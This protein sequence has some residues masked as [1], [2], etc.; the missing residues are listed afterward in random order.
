MTHKELMIEV[1]MLKGNIN[2]MMVTK[3]PQELQKMHE[4]AEYRLYKIYKARVIELD[5]AEEDNE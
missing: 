5:K 3:D 2:R 4:I 1:D